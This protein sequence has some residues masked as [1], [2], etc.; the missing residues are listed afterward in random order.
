MSG[1]PY[2]IDVL[3]NILKVRMR[4]VVIEQISIVEQRVDQIDIL[5]ECVNQAGIDNLENHSHHIFDN[6][7]VL[8]RFVR[9]RQCRVGRR[10]RRGTVLLLG[11]FLK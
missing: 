5:R 3:Q 2:R 10:A 6:G 11:L 8:D 4:S 7:Q 1:T 9:R